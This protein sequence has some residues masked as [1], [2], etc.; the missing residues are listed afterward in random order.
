ME[1][2]VRFGA[3]EY[4]RVLIANNASELRI[5]EAVAGQVG[6]PVGSFG[7]KN[8]DGAT[9]TFHAGLT[10]NWDVVPLPAPAPSVPGA[11]VC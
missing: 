10:G 8:A 5:K 9:S 6:L 4:K 1:F 7:I 3:G 2:R 11:C